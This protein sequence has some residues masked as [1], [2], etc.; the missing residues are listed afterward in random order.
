MRT[1]MSSVARLLLV[2]VA[3]SASSAPA[4][5]RARHSMEIAPR[6]PVPCSPKPLS[7]QQHTCHS[8]T[9]TDLYAANC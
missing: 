2:L 5:V 6:L 4:E 8:E 7:L 1:N 3:L 9:F